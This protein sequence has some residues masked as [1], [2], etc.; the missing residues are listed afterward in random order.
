MT[1]TKMIASTLTRLGARRRL[2]GDETDASAATGAGTH[3]SVL[4]CV[5]N[6]AL[7][8]PSGPKWRNWQTR[9]TQNPVSLGTCGF[10]SHLRHLAPTSAGFGLGA[11]AEPRRRS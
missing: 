11:G 3:Y 6:R 10:D 2:R 4:G 5:V 7:P 9:R 8:C 1:P